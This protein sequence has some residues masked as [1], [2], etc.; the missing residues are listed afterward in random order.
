MIVKRHSRKPKRNKKFICVIS[1]HLHSCSYKS[2]TK[3][4]SARI[5]IQLNFFCVFTI[6][7]V[8]RVLRRDTCSHYFFFF[9]ATQPCNGL[10]QNR[11][12]C[13]SNPDGTYYCICALGFAGVHCSRGDVLTSFSFP[14][15]TVHLIDNSLC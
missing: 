10:C 2:L 11:A 7:R 6:N 13:V 15:C 12:T 1:Q 14:I 9:V 5:R 4:C 3:Q 8:L